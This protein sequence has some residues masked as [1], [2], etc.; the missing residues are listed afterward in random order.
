M[1]PWH[2]LPNAMNPLWP[3]EPDPADLADELERAERAKDP[4]KARKEAPAKAL[5]RTQ[6]R[7]TAEYRRGAGGRTDNIA[8]LAML[9]TLRERVRRETPRCDNG[10]DYTFCWIDGEYPE[11]DDPIEVTFHYKY[12]PWAQY[13][14]WGNSYRYCYVTF[15]VGAQKPPQTA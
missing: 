5:L 2:I 15:D 14:P 3:K 4:K 8:W 6:Q 11:S 1:T 9:R 12:G 7:V 10:T 13:R